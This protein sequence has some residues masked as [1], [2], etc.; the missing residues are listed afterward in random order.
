MPN[1]T[2]YWLASLDTKTR[3]RLRTTLFGTADYFLN[4]AILFGFAAIG[5]IGYTLPALALAYMIAVNALVLAAITSGATRRFRDPS[6]TVFQVF[7]ACSINLL[8]LIIE[9]KIGYLFIVNLFVPLSYGSLHFNRRTYLV[10]WCLLAAALAVILIR[11][12]AVVDITMT[13]PTE[14]L[15]FWG[16]V[17]VTLAR[18]LAINARVSR[19]RA[20]LQAKNDELA[21]ATSR[22]ADLASRDELTGLWNRREFMRLLQDESRRAVRNRTSFCVAL[23][24]VDHFKQINDRLGHLAGDAVLREMGQLLDLARRATDSVARYGGE[25]FTLLLVN[26]KLSTA[27]VALERMRHQITQHQWEHAAAD[28]NITI[29]AGVAEWKPGETLVQVLNRADTALHAAKAEGRNC[30]RAAVT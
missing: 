6:L 10:A 26:A 19:L 15:L 14:R 22:L 27:T 5:T 20:R 28:L 2:L 11:L 1:T 7:A 9:P 29:S 4:V 21:E 23:I 18:F 12:G 13:T 25:Q 3:I 8:G 16:V 17:S 24:D 30:V